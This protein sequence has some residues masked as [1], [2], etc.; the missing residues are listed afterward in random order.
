MGKV[1]FD[2]S[3]SLDGY[4]TATDRTPEEPLG[5]G[6]E[7]LHEWAFG[8]NEKDREFMADSVQNLGAVIAGRTTYDESIRWWG[9]DGPSGAARR[10]V[11]VVTHER[12]RRA[13][14]EAST[15]SSPKG[16]RPPWK[17]PVTRQETTMSRS[18][19]ARA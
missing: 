10:P 17:P 4:I 8:E 14:K 16:S 1:I 9:P 7:R 5:K 18:W 11:I 19:A 13:R 3:M 15:R 12:R 6:G 2:I